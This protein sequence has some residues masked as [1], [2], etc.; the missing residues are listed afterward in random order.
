M[1]TL[2]EIAKLSGVSRSTVSRVI[3][4][5]PHVSDP[6]YKKVMAVVREFNYQPNIAARSLASGHTRVL[7]LVIPTG[8]SKLFTDPYFQI[9]I[10]GVSSACNAHDYSVMLWL[11]EPEYERRMIK[12]ILNNGLVDGVVVS[13][14][15]VDD[16]IVEA[17]VE[18]ELP[19]ML[20]GRHPTVT[21]VNY[22]DVDNVASA[23]EIVTHLLRLGYTRVATITGPLNAI[24][25]VDRYEGYIEALSSRGI[26]IDTGLI[27]EGDFSEEGGYYAMRRLLSQ[28]PQAVFVASDPM[29][30]GAMRA[31]HE[32]GLSI[33]EDV[34][35]VGFDDIPAS[36]RSNPPLT[37]IRQPVHMLGSVAVKTLIDLIEHPVADLHHIILPTQLV[38]RESCGVDLIS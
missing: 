14:M 7:G 28:S 11:A 29:A 27:V 18:S 31:L 9:L 30:M 35:L 4:N 8:V 10:Q 15:V 32:A 2:E 33:P 21:D 26:K 24:S 6:T 38:I 36:A 17:L 20:I 12:K 16:V 13:S 5:D 37:T 34:A 25:G 23:K 19:F 22:V 3:N 1:P